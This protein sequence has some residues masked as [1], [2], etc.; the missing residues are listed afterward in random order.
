MKLNNVFLTVVFALLACVGIAE[1]KLNPMFTDH[2]VLQRNQ[3]VPVYGTADPGEK[4]TVEFAGQVKTAVADSS[5]HWKVLLD[6]MTASSEP[7]KLVVLSDSQTPILQY[8]NVL[9]GDVWL[10]AGQSNMATEIRLYPTLREE[11]ADVLNN[12]MVRL[13]KFKR[14]GVGCE[15]PSKEVVIDPPFKDSWQPMT[16]DLAREF[17]ATGAFFGH[18]LQPLAGIPI[19]LL[20]ANRGGTAVNQWLPMEF[21]M[22]KPD[23]YAPFLGPDN[24]WWKESDRN[25]GLIRAPSRLFNGTINPVIPFAIRGCIWY[26]GESDDRYSPIYGEMISDLITV[27]RGLWGTDFDFLFVQLAPYG[28]LHW[29]ARGE[30]WAFQREAQDAALALPK[31]ARAVII[32]SGEQL[33]I[34]PQNKQP[35][36]QR[37]ALLAANLDKPEIAAHSPEFESAQTAGNRIRITFKNAGSGL[38]TRRVAM[39][40]N[41]RLE[42]GMDPEAFVVEAGT[43]AGF[44]VCGADQK[45]V[46]A[47]AKIIGRDTVEVWADGVAEPVAVRY[48]WA[49]FPLCNL[50][51]SDGLPACPFRSDNFPPPDFTVSGLSDSAADIQ[52]VKLEVR[53]DFS[54][55]LS[56]KWCNE[57]PAEWSVQ[58]GELW[59]GMATS[60]HYTLTHSDAVGDGEM[61]I[62]LSATISSGS[63]SAWGGIAFNVQDAENF[64]ML[65]IK[66]DNGMVQLV[67]LAGAAKPLVVDTETLATPFALNTQYTLRLQFSPKDRFYVVT[68]T[69]TATGEVLIH[70]TKVEAAPMFVSGPA[71]LYGGSTSTNPDLFI[72]DDFVF[73]AGE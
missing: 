70:R 8:S 28:V 66:F 34:H 41:K 5:K 33:D 56:R 29:D 2:M 47:Q 32:D 11:K 22:S 72:F 1:V 48:G 16:P 62:D 46:E 31:T 35:V 9:V 25:P 20:Y 59:A 12:P 63:R 69:D 26:Q 4:I 60:S 30:A 19:G 42:P 61:K 36:G 52:A 51:S 71:G 10:C 27:W 44:T 24:P 49:N 7:R 14:E 43:L 40:K 57:H 67:R 45:F 58:A 17:S 73:K 54:A 68:I 13:F 50:Y 3:S 18:A 65:R 6:P 38:E 53:D 64:Y 39:N 21:M 55:P 23:L 37:L 15:E